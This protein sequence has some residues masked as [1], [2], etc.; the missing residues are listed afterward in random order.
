MNE[1]IVWAGFLLGIAGSAH[2]I[3]MCGPLVLALPSSNSNIK[4]LILSRTIYHLSRS[5]AYAAMGCVLGFIGFGFSMVGIQKYVSISA[6]IIMLALIFIPSRFRSGFLHASFIS[7]P[8]SLKS[9]IQ[10]LMKSDNLVSLSILGF[11]NGL[12][13]C[14][15]VY[16]G[17]MGAV[18][19]GS[20]I[21]SAL[22]MF[23]FGLGTLPVMLVVSVLPGFQSGKLKERL[24]AAFPYIVVVV[25]LLLILR[26]LGLGIPFLSPDLGSGGMHTM[27]H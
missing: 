9:A 15:F 4:S 21:E 2:C 13:P 18:G 11:L 12:L 20:P 5:F 27:Q 24:N 23:L 19:M 14:G 6:G 8:A 25:A 22:F 10:R 3:G 16:L 26:G 17:L 7:M 1:S